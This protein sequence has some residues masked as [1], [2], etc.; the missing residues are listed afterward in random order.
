MIFMANNYEKDDYIG[1]K[2]KCKRIEN[3][4]STSV[5]LNNPDFYSSYKQT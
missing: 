5:L 1:Q 2:Q 3:Y 4:P